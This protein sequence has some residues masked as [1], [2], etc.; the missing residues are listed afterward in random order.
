MVRGLL[1]HNCNV[2]IGNLRH[3]PKIIM[4]AAEY[5]ASPPAVVAMM[6]DQ[7][8][9]QQGGLGAHVIP[10]CPSTGIMFA[11]LVTHCPRDGPHTGRDDQ[12]ASRCRRSSCSRQ[13]PRTAAR[14]SNPYALRLF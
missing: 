2:G 4:A 3:D 5:L 14:Y 1:C 13:S 9:P 7:S 6:A 8:R 11:P 12:R 10:A